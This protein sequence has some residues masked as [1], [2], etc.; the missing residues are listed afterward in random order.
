MQLFFKSTKA[1]TFARNWLSSFFI[2]TKLSSKTHLVFVKEAFLITC[3]LGIWDI[4]VLKVVDDT[5]TWL[6][7]QKNKQLDLTMPSL[8]L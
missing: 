1:I 4:F 3:H 6:T 5:G 2:N 7:C 8:F